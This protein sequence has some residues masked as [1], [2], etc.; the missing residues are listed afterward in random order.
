MELADEI[1]EKMGP[2]LTIELR[3]ISGHSGVAGNEL[4]DEEAKKASQG[5]SSEARLLPSFL[6]DYIL[7]HS[8][9]ALKQAHLK[10]LQDV[11]RARWRVSPRYGKISK[12]DP[13][14]PFTKYQKAAAKLTR[15]QTSV[16]VQLRTGHIGLN[17]HLARIKKADSPLCPSCHVAE[18]SVHHFMFECPAYQNERHHL[19]RALGRKASSLKYLLNHEKG[20]SETLKYMGRTGRLRRG[21]GDVTPSIP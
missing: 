4:V 16:I 10:K 12:I 9:A 13:S 21:F 6:T 15:S 8:I 5:D 18:E 1:I 17:K 7:G 3:W 20:I 14:F 19:A 2:G 11:W